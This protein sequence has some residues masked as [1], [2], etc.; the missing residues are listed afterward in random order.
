[1]PLTYHSKRFFR[2]TGLSLFG[3][4][5][6]YQLVVAALTGL[7]DLHAAP[8][9]VYLIEM[10]DRKLKVAVEDRKAAETSLNRALALAPDNPDYLATLGWLQ[11]LG[12]RQEGDA[13]IPAEKVRLETLAYQYYAQ[14]AA[15]RPT[16]PYDWGDMAV[17]QYGLASFSGSSYHQA[18][19]NAARFGP[20]KD[21]IQLLVTELGLDTWDDLNLAARQAL[22]MTIDRGLLRQADTIIAIIEAQAAWVTVCVPGQGGSANF[23]ALL[24]LRAECQSRIALESG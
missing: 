19:V 13:L 1:M 20:W 21:D 11:Q 15:Q 4:L 18:L 5:L 3:A 24:H 22:L 17:E 8:A 14:A 9:M 7:A 2:I 6:V 10:Q 23:S 12:L 16:W